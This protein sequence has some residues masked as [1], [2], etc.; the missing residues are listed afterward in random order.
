MKYLTKH[1]ETERNAKKLAIQMV[2]YGYYKKDD[3]QQFIKANHLYEMPSYE[4][5]CN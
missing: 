5:I 4:D 3:Y 1:V 2:K